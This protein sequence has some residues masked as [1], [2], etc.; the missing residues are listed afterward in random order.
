[1]PRYGYE[2]PPREVPKDDNGY[3]EELTKAVFRAGFSWKVIHDRWPDFQAAFDGFDINRV[4][5]YD[6]RDLD[7]LLSNEKIVRNGRKIEATIYNARVMREIIAE[8]GSFQAYLR[9]LDHM[10]YS[11]R[12]KVLSKRFKNLGPTSVFVFLYSVGEE[13]P[14]WEDRKK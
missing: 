11:E 7:R 5:A 10:P 14:K 8:H 12:R 3:F 9:S 6:E 2:V 1:M 13:V 4:A